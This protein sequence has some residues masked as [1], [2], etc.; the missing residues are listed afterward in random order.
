M[1]LDLER[2]AG[3]VDMS[4]HWLAGRVARMCC[5]DRYFK[6]RRDTSLIKKLL[7]RL[8]ANQQNLDLSNNKPKLC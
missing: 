4:R 3:Y 5:K 8:V 6:I 1:R 7:L 2:F